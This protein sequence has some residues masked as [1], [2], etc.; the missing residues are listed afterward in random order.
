MHIQINTISD[1]KKYL[2]LRLENLYS[3]AEI[4]VIAEIIIKTLF[5]L[6]R[7]QQIQNPDYEIPLTKKAQVEQI[8][9][10]LVAGKPV[11]YV[12][13][14]TIFYNCIIKLNSH[15]F[16]PRQETEELVDL[17]VKENLN[18]KGKILDIGTGPG[19]IAIALAANM[20]E[21]EVHAI[22]ISYEALEMAR[23]NANLNNVKVKFFLADIL[24]PSWDLPEFYDIVVSNPP[25]IPESEKKIMHINITNYEP[26]KALFVPDNDPLIFYRSILRKNHLFMASGSKIYF[27]IHEKMGEKIKFLMAG[28]DI[29][30]IRLI[31]DIND[32]DRI[33]TGIFYG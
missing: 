18:F 32:K 33:I 8:C 12:T 29:R 26:A 31:K 13:G 7:L 24:N 19:S 20:P 5:N 15:T 14:E 10:D 6:N 21:A 17:I 22:D 28:S 25:Y 2:L 27:E 3:E 11:Q 16:I 23:E 9:N 1:L 4:A 30:D